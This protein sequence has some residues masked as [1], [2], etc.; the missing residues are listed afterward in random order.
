MVVGRIVCLLGRAIGEMAVDGTLE[1]GLD[2]R[3][4]G[5]EED[6]DG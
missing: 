6:G 3:L 5:E 2:G 4:Q 1:R